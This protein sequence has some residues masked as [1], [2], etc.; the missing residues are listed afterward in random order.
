MS[1]DLE[2]PSARFTWKTAT[3]RIGR[4]DRERLDHG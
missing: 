1:D 2:T 3:G 4:E